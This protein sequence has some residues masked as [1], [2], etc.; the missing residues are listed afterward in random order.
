M[1]LSIDD[2]GELVVS[3]TDTVEQTALWKSR[4]GAISEK[5]RELS[6]LIARKRYPPCLN[7]LGFI[8]IIPKEDLIEHTLAKDCMC[9]PKYSAENRTY[10][11]HAM[12][13]RE[14]YARDS[15]DWLLIL[16]S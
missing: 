2:Y 12:D 3:Y 14:K 15:S 11:H 16:T 7:E 1:S 10:R 5:L 9:V 4:Y 8:H 6:D 13:G